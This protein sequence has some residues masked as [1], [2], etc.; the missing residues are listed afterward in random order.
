MMILLYIIIAIWLIVFLTFFIKEYILNSINKKYTLFINEHS[1][2]L[3]NLNSIND[4]Y[5]F[6]DIPCLD[7]DESYDNEYY[8][9]NI[10]PKDYL[11]YQLVHIQQ[12]VKEA[13]QSAADNKNLFEEYQKEM[14]DMCTI[15]KYDTDTI[16]LNPK[17]LLKTENEIISSKKKY[18]TVVF[19]IKVMIWLTYII[20]KPYSRKQQ[21]FNSTEIND[22]IT[23]VNRKRGSYYLDDEVWK[24][25]CR[26][27][28]G[29][30]T[31]RV[32]F[33]IYRR[34]NYRCRK[35]GRKSNN[36]EI[37]HIFPISKGGKS[38]LDNLQS[39]C[40]SC[41]TAKANAVEYGAT[42]PNVW[43]QG[44][45]GNCPRCGATLVMKKGRYGIFYA[46]PNYPRCNYTRKE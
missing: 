33:Y 22:I 32:R 14:S 21:T 10:S 12:H 36:L 24:S 6:A 27:E 3:R 16:P 19:R 43:W 26:V 29:K 7:M 15:G 25:I 31:N 1:I 37:D 42:N 4:K 28:R 5:S 38:T 18:P 45:H 17:K 9:N 34:D 41:N 2:A 46:C 13:I 23:A 35:C 40:H 44:E 11:T 20:G 39:L 8:Y 30:V